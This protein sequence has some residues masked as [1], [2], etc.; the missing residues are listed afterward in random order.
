MESDRS[1]P[2][3][4]KPPPGRSFGPGAKDTE[5]VLFSLSHAREANQHRTPEIRTW[6][7]RVFHH[8]QHDVCHADLLLPAAFQCQDDRAGPECIIHGC[9]HRAFA[10]ACIWQADRC[11]HRSPGRLPERQITEFPGQA[12]PIHAECRFADIPVQRADL[13]AHTQ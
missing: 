10:R 3:R 12:H 9:H 4:I 13:P 8:V 1:H 11:G 2:A 6:R 7:I 5:I